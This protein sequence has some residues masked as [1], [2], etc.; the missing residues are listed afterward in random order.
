MAKVK[1][2]HHITDG[3]ITITVRVHERYQM[4]IV[5]YIEKHCEPVNIFAVHDTLF[6]SFINGDAYKFLQ[7]F[8]R[9]IDEIVEVVLTYK[10]MLMLRRMTDDEI[11][12]F[13]QEKD[14]SIE[15]VEKVKEVYG[16]DGIFCPNCFNELETTTELT[17]CPHCLKEKYA[18]IR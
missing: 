11:I 17:R 13:F 8:M 2:D 18:E 3:V 16:Q 14:F 12:N 10:E 5:R 7:G 9:N 1:F 4:S 6:V 15:Y